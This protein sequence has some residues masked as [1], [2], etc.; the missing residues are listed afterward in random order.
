MTSTD[1]KGR[2]AAVRQW[3]SDTRAALVA[4]VREQPVFSALFAA[5]VA[6]TVTAHWRSPIGPGQDFHYHLMV[7]AVNARGASDP[8]S[9]LYHP[10]SWFDANTLVYRVAFPFEKLLDPVRAFGIAVLLLYYLG[11]PLAVA[12]ALKRTGRAPW[13]ALFAFTSVYCKAWSSNGFVPF[14]TASTFMVLALAEWSVLLDRRAD[15]PPRTAMIR[16]ALFSTL[17]FL[18]HGHVYAWTTLLLGLFTVVAIGRDLASFRTDTARAAA[19]RAFD[20]AWRSLVAIGPSLLLFG[21]WFLRTQR[22]AAAARTGHALVPVDPSIES[23]LLGLWVYF[24][25]S[26]DKHEFHYFVAFALIVLAML[27]LARRENRRAPWFE[28]FSLLSIASFFALPETVNAQTIG[29]RHVDIA[30]WTLPLALWPADESTVERPSDAPKPSAWRR[31]LREYVLAAMVFAFAFGRVRQITTAHHNAYKSETGP[32]VAL[33]EPCRRARR[34]PFSVLGYV[35]MTRESAVLHSPHMHQAHET[36]A[37]LCGV[38]TPVYDTSVFPHNL[39]PLR[40]RVPM[41][42]PVYI[43]ERDPAW[44]ANE[45]LWQKFDLVLTSN[46]A[47]TAADEAPLNARAELVAT[48]GT[49]RL[50]RRR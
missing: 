14:Y 42:A 45:L 50:Y 44:Y 11:F 17:L 38:E 18:A 35:P 8:V 25:H 13:A 20:T 26:R 9:A 27:L 21:L 33:A 30:L 40:Y 41:P 4:A 23:K 29:P 1:A 7:A 22:G 32:I 36:L 31:P 46:W 48:S 16:G 12:Y 43:L 28:W 6:L 24:V 3:L 15:Q 37:A 19:K 39:L 34:A 49:F 5:L 10:V 47:P 2:L